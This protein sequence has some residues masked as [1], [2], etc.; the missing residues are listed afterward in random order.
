MYFCFSDSHHT[1]EPSQYADGPSSQIRLFQI[2][3]PTHED[4]PVRFKTL[5]ALKGLKAM[6]VYVHFAKE[7]A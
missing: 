3:L 4:D 6:T 2:D 7:D 1:Q 5:C